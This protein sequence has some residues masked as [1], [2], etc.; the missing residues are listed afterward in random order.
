MAVKMLLLNAPLTPSMLYPESSTFY[1]RQLTLP[2][3]YTE[4]STFLKPHLLLLKWLDLL[5]FFYRIRLGLSCELSKMMYFAFAY[6]HLCYGIEIC[7][8]TYHSY[9]NKL[10]I[11]NNK[12]LQILQNESYRICHRIYENYNTLSVRKLNNRILLLVHKFTYHKSKL[13]IVFT[14]YFNDEYNARGKKITSPNW[15]QYIRFGE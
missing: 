7:G 5:A 2:M 6:S 11:L 9:L 10:I 4:S 15:L 13:P 3:P 8:N 12:I 1:Y 14:I